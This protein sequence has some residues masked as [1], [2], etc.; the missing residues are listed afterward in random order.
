MRA[1]AN[2]SLTVADRLERQ[3]PFAGFFLGELL[4]EAAVRKGKWDWDIA[5]R[6]A[7]EDLY[8]QRE[9]ERG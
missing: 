5:V 3:R 1:S 7:L 6:D 2:S 4:A 9:A 8:R